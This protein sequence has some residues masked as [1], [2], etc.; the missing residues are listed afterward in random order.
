MQQRK[1]LEEHAVRCHRLQ[2][3]RRHQYHEFKKPN[4]E[5]AIPA[6]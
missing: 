3:A 4:V 5:I 6:Q 2:H 1:P